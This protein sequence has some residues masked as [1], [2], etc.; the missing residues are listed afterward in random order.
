MTGRIR[1]ATP[2]AADRTDDGGVTS[3]NVPAADHPAR[4]IELQQLRAERDKLREKLA[5]GPDELILL[6]AEV[7]ALKIAAARAG[8]TDKT[9]HMSEGVREEL[10][11]VGYATDPG[12]GALLTRE[13]LP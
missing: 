11:R 3:A 9:R 7:Q 2:A 5:G 6:R 8:V 13:D 4:I 12:T 10:D 1:K